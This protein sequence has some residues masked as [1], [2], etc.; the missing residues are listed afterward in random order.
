MDTRFRVF[1]YKNIEEV[2][3]KKV[4]IVTALAGFVRSF[5]KNDIVTLQEMGYTVECAANKNHPGA[6]KIEEFFDEMNVKFYDVPFSSNS[7]FS[8]QTLVAYKSISQLLKNNSYEM[9]HVHTPIAGA[10]VKLA[11]RKY[12]KKGCKIVYTTHGFYFHS[13]SS[14]KT[15][16]LYFNF[17]KLLSKYTDYIITINKEDYSN[18]K[19]MYCKN[20]RYINGVGVNTEKFEN[21][22]IDKKAYREKENIATSDIVVMSVGELSNRKN[23]RIIVE[24]LAKLNDD[25]YLYIIC[26]NDMNENG[27]SEQL[28]ELAKEKNVRIRLLGLRDDIPQLCKMADIGAFPSSREGLGLAGIEMLAS[29]MSIVS[30]NVQGIKDYMEDGKTGYAYNPS[31]ADGF[32]EGIKKLTDENVREK[33]SEY[34]VRKAKQFDINISKTQMKHIYEE[35]L[36]RK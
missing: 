28:K 13:Q 35:V 17:E 27:T 9:I 1:R 32:A 30:S 29:G 6:G 10:V 20:I 11:A 25:R 2:V 8:K 14:K 26:G 24:A 12:R 4:L 31:D 5:L 21:V 3:M 36:E 19:K 34:C 23:H 15:W 18:A 7:P 22:K 16:M 33:M